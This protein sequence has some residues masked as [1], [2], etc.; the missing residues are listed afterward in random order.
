M[1]LYRRLYSLLILLALLPSLWSKA[2]SQSPMQTGQWAKIAIQESGLY[3][4]TS[5]DIASLGL[6]NLDKV[7]VWG[8]GGALLPEQIVGLAGRDLQEVPT[9]LVDGKLYFYGVGTVS[10]LYDRDKAFFYHQIN[11]YTRQGYYLISE[12]GEPMRMGQTEAQEVGEAGEES[13]LYTDVLHHEQELYSPSQSG[14]KLY[15]ESMLASQRL[16]FTHKLP[17]A[18]SARMRFAYMAYPTKSDARLSAQIGGQ[19]YAEENISLEE[20][21]RLVSSSGY[22]V[23]GIERT[24]TTA[25]S[26]PLSGENLQ[27]DFTLSAQGIS[28]HL[29]YYELNVERTLSYRGGQMSFSRA[30]SKENKAAR[31]TYTISQASGTMLLRVDNSVSASLVRQQISSSSLS[32]ALPA[33]GAGGMPSRYLLLRLSDAYK[34][35]LVGRVEN[36]NLIGTA[37]VPD[38]LIIT[39]DALRVESVRLANYYEGK[40]QKVLVATQTEV[41]NEFN[42]GTPDATAYRLFAR[43]LYD[44]YQTKHP[45]GDCPMQLLLVGD[46]AQDNRKLTTA[47]Q[48][49]EMQHTEFL[50]SYQSVASLDL[51]SYTSDDYFGVLADEEL[52]TDNYS[53]EVRY[54]HLYELAMDI[55]VGRLPVRSVAQARAVID[56]I[57]AYD[58]GSDYGSW[59][60]R[61]A[62]IADNG[63]GNSHTRQSIEIS[64]G[65]E[66]QMPE[67]QLRKIYMAAYPRV[68][69]GG[70]TTVPRAHKALMDALQ[71]GVLI[72]N[73]NGHGNPQSW[74]DEQILTMSD[75]QN[76]SYPHLPLWI[77]AT[78][79]F[80]NFDAFSTSAGEE[81]LLHPSSGGVALLSTTR[82]VWDIPNQMLNTAILKELFTPDADGKPRPL[83]QVVRDAKNSLRLRST[84]ENRLNFILLG[85]PLT[86]IAVPPARLKVN[87]LTDQD[88]EDGQIIDL[89]ALERVRMEGH[90]QTAGGDVD[91]DFSGKLELWVYDGE[92]E[93]ETIDNFNR[94]NTETRPARYRDYRNIIYSGGAK[95]EDGRYSLEFSIPKDVAYSGRK[96]R[97][98][99]YARDEQRG[100]E[101]IGLS[102]SFVIK[103]GR[104]KQTIDDTDSPELVSIRL[105]GQDALGSKLP[106]VA[107][108]TLLEVTLRDSSAIN[109]S[110]SG[111]GH[112][113]MLTIDGKANQSYD[114]SRYYTASLEEQGLGEVKFVLEG[115]SAGDHKAQ[116]EV[117]DVYNNATRVQFAF[118]VE[119]ALAPKIEVL[120]LISANE[121]GQIPKLRLRHNLSGMN[122]QARIAIYDMLGQMVWSYDKVQITASATTG[123]DYRI[124]LSVLDGEHLS[125]LPNGAYLVRLWLGVQEGAEASASTKWLVKR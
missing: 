1:N 3:V 80:A 30:L 114:L 23:Y 18:Q 69:V 43:K 48:I 71:E 60:M 105:S 75:I 27:V 118:R 49:P 99:L 119:P 123:T 28:S 116:L 16:S 56:K 96:G 109:L 44:L 97:I 72:A 110:T 2:W 64:D 47:W 13:R 94:R 51:E 11:H 34:P 108:S 121:G 85:S 36:Q 45:K 5:G 77:T 50:L 63:D 78:C 12:G 15:G 59:K 20:M 112:R 7:R 125:S 84:P 65:L 93:L 24:H 67:L 22:K 33:R 42:G 61:A 29:D 102:Q 101:T 32:L 100:I 90:V 10:W 81:I 122:L 98:S 117:W 57:I 73:Y 70:R 92:E 38:L 39:T 106:L 124:D 91:G 58:R 82:V 111:I 120:E 17:G 9:L 104:A 87:R 55:G 74:A 115:L 86:Y 21:N 14:R 37:E 26:I 66:Q 62:F 31:S 41:F 6:K 53:N 103:T 54:P 89:H 8:Y 19:P 95:I 88:L 25:E 76:F 113:L 4:L 107:S 46:G 79:D 83:G 68:N 35:A 40:G 52:K